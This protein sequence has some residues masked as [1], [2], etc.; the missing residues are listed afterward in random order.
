M[1]SATAA[2]A[3][4]AAC[5]SSNIDVAVAANIRLHRTPHG[6]SRGIYCASPGNKH[7]IFLTTLLVLILYLSCSPP[8][9]ENLDSHLTSHAATLHGNDC[10]NLRVLSAG[11][12]SRQPTTCSSLENA[13]R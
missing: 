8:H 2:C 13:A 7:G 10:H 4:D 3:L 1:R 6:R 9:Q 12:N 5:S 11:D